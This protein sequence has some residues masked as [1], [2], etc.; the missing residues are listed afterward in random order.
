[1]K[2]EFNLANGLTFH[3]ILHFNALE[4]KFDLDVK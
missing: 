1:M 2:F 4:S 3:K